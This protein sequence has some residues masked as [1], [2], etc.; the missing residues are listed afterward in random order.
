MKTPSQEPD[1][2]IHDKLLIACLEYVKFN[3]R[4]ETK[5]TI[6]AYYNAQRALR[7]LRAITDEKI[8]QMRIDFHHNDPRSPSYER[9]Q[10][11]K[12]NEE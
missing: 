2:D 6:Y 12:K 8:R 1:D 9:N 10:E 11:K 4:W 5:N 7:K 3:E